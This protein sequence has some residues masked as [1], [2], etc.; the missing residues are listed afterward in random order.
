MLLR[1]IAV[2]SLGSR[3]TVLKNMSQN[4]CRP[5]SLAKACGPVAQAVAESGSYGPQRHSWVRK[6][7]GEVEIQPTPVFI[8]A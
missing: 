4:S 5:T 1:Q 6:T 8:L 3:A 2:L 7:P